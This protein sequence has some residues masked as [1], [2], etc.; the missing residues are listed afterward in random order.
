MDNLSQV[1]LITGASSGIGAAC[2]LKFAQLNAKLSLVGRNEE[3][4]KII[5]EKCEEVSSQR[6][7][8]IT[9]DVSIDKD[10]ERIVAETIKHYGRINVL[11]NNAGITSL[12]GISSGVA[13][14]DKIM[15]TNLRGPYLLTSLTLPHL[16]KTK[17]SVINISSALS[18]KPNYNM[19]AYCMSKAAVDMFTRCLALEFGPQGV[20]VNAVNPGPVRTE[21]FK[22]A[23]VSAEENDQLFKVMENMMPLKKVSDSEEVAELVAYLASDKARSITGSCYSIDCG[24]LLGEAVKCENE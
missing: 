14:Y 24:L 16:V 1:I 20:R 8:Y 2:A 12:G 18:T 22:R 23:G 21:V 19:T 4:L 9:T 10:V 13:E 6:H 7:L 3:K 5:S 11:V 17:G 15:A